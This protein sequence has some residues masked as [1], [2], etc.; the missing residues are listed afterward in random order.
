VLYSLWYATGQGTE[1]ASEEDCAGYGSINY[2]LADIGRCDSATIET[3]DS[4]RIE[5]SDGGENDYSVKPEL[6]QHRISMDYEDCMKHLTTCPI[7]HDAMSDPV[8]AQ[9]GYTY[10]RNAIKEWFREQKAND[11]PTT[12]PMTNERIDEQLISNYALRSM[13]HDQR[14]QATQAHEGDSNTVVPAPT[15][16][17]TKTRV[18]LEDAKK[19]LRGVFDR[20]SF[21]K[22]LADHP[23]FVD[24]F[25]SD[26]V[27]AIF[28]SDFDLYAQ[29]GRPSNKRS[30]DDERAFVV[31]FFLSFAHTGQVFKLSKPNVEGRDYCLDAWFPLGNRA[32]TKCGEYYNG[33]KVQKKWS[34]ERKFYTDMPK[35]MDA[36]YKRL[37]EVENLLQGVLTFM[38]E[39]FH[40]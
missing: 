27:K 22:E 40:I 21:L 17:T 1:T 35:E 3:R 34:K 19:I 20:E 11:R 7:T 14:R 6:N 15:S 18:A 37:C 13:F 2:K 25:G 24:A 36:L 28:K 23:S 9:D 5:S 12:S 10:E 8:F 31:L 38:G 26:G 33:R 29:R 4:S 30:R 39:K 32:G 16:T